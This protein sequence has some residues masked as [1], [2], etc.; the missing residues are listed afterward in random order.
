MTKTQYLAMVFTNEDQFQA[1]THRYINNNYPQT[2]GLCFHVPNE[3]ASSDLMRMK[4]HAKGIIPGIP[5]I[6]CISPV[7]GLE[8]KMPNGTHSDKQ[9]AI[10]AIW[11]GKD[12][13]FAVC[14]NAEEVCLFLETLLT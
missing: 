11:K 9:K 7:F 6:V 12:I 13:P 5:D 10:M 3:S 2:R 1:A 8:L 14:Y 4:L